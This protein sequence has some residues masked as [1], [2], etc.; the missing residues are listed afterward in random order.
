MGITYNDAYRL[1]IMDKVQIHPTSF[2]DPS[3]PNASPKILAPGIFGG[4]SG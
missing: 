2:V 3:A 4:K 1:K